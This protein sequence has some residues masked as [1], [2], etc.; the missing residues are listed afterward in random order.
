MHVRLF[1]FVEVHV[2]KNSF[3][4]TSFDTNHVSGK[5]AHLIAADAKCY[6]NIRL[7]SLAVLLDAAAM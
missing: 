4:A 6:R 1:Q 3:D 7:Y 2:E 5:D